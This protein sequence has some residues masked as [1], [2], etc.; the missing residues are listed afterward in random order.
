[1]IT[2][3]IGFG[4]F[5]HSI[6]GNIEVFFLLQITLL[7]YLKFLSLAIVGN[8]IGGAVVVGLSSIEFQNQIT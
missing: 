5:H 8:A 3:V 1:M 4:G 7:D 2:G 6:V